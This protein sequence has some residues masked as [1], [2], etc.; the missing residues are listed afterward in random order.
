VE[1]KY[2]IMERVIPIGCGAFHFFREEG[3]EKVCMYCKH[4]KNKKNSNQKTK[5]NMKKKIYISGKITGL[6]TDVATK[7]FKD[8]ENYA[9]DEMGYEPVNPMELCEQDDTWEWID[10]MRVDIKALVDCD[11][12]LMLPNWEDS[13]GAKLELVIAQGLKLEIY[14]I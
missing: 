5:I 11:A 4:V 9:K 7:L 8:A 6:D 10:Y 2:L 14:Y 13:D 3:K 12:I 1:Y